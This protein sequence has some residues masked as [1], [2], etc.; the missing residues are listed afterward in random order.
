MLVGF[1]VDLQEDLFSI[2]INLERKHL[3]ICLLICLSVYLFEAVYYAMAHA[4]LG[5]TR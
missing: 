1:S 3:F 5:V 4:H 2:I